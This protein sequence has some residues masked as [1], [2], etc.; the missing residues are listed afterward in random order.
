VDALLVL[1][2]PNSSNSKRLV[3][4]AKTH[5]CPMA[6]LVQRASDIDWAALDGI[7]RLGITAGAS[8]PEILVEEV[9]D[10]AR[11]RFDVTVEELRTATENVV[12]KLPK[13]LIEDMSG[14]E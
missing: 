13:A 10:A 6:Q 4:V 11:A 9:I 8:A 7:R 1:G 3:E 12:F 14:Q 2:A 5:G